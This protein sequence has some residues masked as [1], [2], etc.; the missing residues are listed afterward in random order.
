VLSTPSGVQSLVNSSDNTDPLALQR[1]LA[2]LR[3]R[4]CP[5]CASLGPSRAFNA[6]ESDVCTTAWPW[7]L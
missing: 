2:K 6:A 3:A 1:A 5:T 7:E 4:E